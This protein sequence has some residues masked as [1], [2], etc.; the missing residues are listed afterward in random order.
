MK[1]NKDFPLA[2]STYIVQT[3]I[4]DMIGDGYVLLVEI[5]Q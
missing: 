4:Y 2:I 1:E 5:F 3:D